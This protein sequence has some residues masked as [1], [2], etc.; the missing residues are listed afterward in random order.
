MLNKSSIDINASN[1]F[2]ILGVP[3]YLLV[4]SKDKHQMITFDDIVHV[5][6]TK[7]EYEAFKKEINKYINTTTI[8][9]TLGMVMYDILNLD[10]NGISLHG[11]FEGEDS[12]SGTVIVKEDLER[13]RGIIETAYYLMACSMGEET[14]EATIHNVSKQYFYFLS[15]ESIPVT[16]E[17]SVMG[18]TENVIP[19]FM[20]K[21]TAIKALKSIAPNTETQIEID[22]LF[23]ISQ[24]TETDFKGFSIGAEMTT[25]NSYVDKESVEQEHFSHA[26][27]WE[28][29]SLNSYLK[30]LLNKDELFI[31]LS[32][33]VDISKG[34]GSPLFFEDSYGDKSIL[35]FERKED[36]YHFLDSRP[37][38]TV[39]EIRPLGTF[40]P[41]TSMKPLMEE[42]YTNDVSKF[43]FNINTENHIELSIEDLYKKVY[44]SQIKKVNVCHNSTFQIVDVDTDMLYDTEVL[45]TIKHIL[46][47]SSKYDPII[48]SINLAYDCTAEELLYAI[49]YLNTQISQT[50]IDN[51]TKS[52]WQDI[53]TN[54]CTVLLLRLEERGDIF[55]VCDKEGN[56][57]VEN[58]SCTILVS[59]KYM[60]PTSTMFPIK[61]IPESI[62][63]I[64][65]CC[66]QITITDGKKMTTTIP[67]DV[68]FSSIIQ[69]GLKKKKNKILAYF[70]CNS[71][72]SLLGIRW[73]FGTLLTNK[74]LFNEVIYMIE[75]GTFATDMLKINEKTAKDFM[76][77][78]EDIS[79][80]YISFVEYIC[81]IIPDINS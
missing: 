76:S 48:P 37:Q 57:M 25:I 27:P 19:V 39:N 28:L 58:N 29:N 13:K 55:L 18:K 8:K 16:I 69:E 73:F 78:N 70:S 44:Q 15:N 60:Q 21:T 9:A 14:P 64:A 75:K 59:T 36:A 12:F 22:T 54:L 31:V 20:T 33:K 49:E 6:N 63:E 30:Y 26:N 3:V 62:K 5:F 51:N 41:F 17:R 77:S 24:K 65:Q 74:T 10:L 66:Q 7:S 81:D 56:P 61:L 68:V 79:S 43:I 42:F 53:R 52:M 32:S 35:I 11:F 72:L 34:K 1:I 4:D 67:I 71:D 38:K 45:D 47:S 46:D 80:A 40:N 50:S 2:D 23:N